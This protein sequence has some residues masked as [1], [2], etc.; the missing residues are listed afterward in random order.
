[1]QVPEEV[2]RPQLKIIQEP[3]VFLP[4]INP[5]WGQTSGAIE[6]SS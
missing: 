5:T 1:M 2:Y 3:T 6:I 4:L